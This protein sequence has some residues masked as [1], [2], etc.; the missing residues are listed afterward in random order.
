M[1]DQEQALNPV[2]E[3]T[4]QTESPAEEQTAEVQTDVSAET[5]VV[6]KKGAQ[7]RIRELSGEVHSLRDRIAELTQQSTTASPQMPFTP[8][9]YRPLVG[10]DESIDGQELE[11]RM[12]EREQRILQQASQIADFKA[13]QAAVLANINQQ[14]DELVRKYKELDPDPTNELF[15]KELSDDVYE[16]VEAKLKAEPTADVRKIVAKQIELHRRAQ[17][18]EEAKTDAVIAKQAAQSAIRP[19]Q[20]KTVDTPFERLSIEEMRSKLGYAS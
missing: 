16:I 9:E 3:E 20:N 19:T 18:R 1:D 15:D 6:P 4:A 14:A 17:A 2:A 13:R 10:A 8:Q 12:Q 7:S 11:R 5:P